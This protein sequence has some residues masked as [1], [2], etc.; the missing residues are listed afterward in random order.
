MN[1]TEASVK[2][3]MRA[4]KSKLEVLDQEFKEKKSFRF[5]DPP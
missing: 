4:H 1:I 3:Q 5:T 2:F